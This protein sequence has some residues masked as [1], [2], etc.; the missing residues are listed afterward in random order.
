MKLTV[1]TFLTLDGAMQGPGGPDDDRTDGF[2]K[3]EHGSFALE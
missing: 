1:T 2:G 3:V